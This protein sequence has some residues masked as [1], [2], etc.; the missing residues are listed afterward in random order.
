MAYRFAAQLEV[1]RKVYHLWQEVGV[2]HACGSATSQREHIS[3]E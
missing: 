1:F 3:G 2:Y